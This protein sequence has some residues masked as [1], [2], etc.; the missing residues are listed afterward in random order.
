MAAAA[1]LLGAVAIAFGAAAEVL[2]VT[3]AY[4][5]MAAVLREAAEGAA[6]GTVG[7]EVATA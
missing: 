6:A 7:S 1:S 4:G 2:A 3:G 5:S